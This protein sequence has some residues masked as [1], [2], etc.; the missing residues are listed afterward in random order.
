MCLE[1][2]RLPNDETLYGLAP[3][4]KREVIRAGSGGGPRAQLARRGSSPGGFNQRLPRASD[5][6]NATESN[7]DETE[8]LHD[9]L[10]CHLVWRLLDVEG[11]LAALIIYPSSG[12]R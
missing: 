3:V 7:G 9:F 6:R 11:V 5:E 4:Q 2:D 8:C 1:S 12:S 10:S